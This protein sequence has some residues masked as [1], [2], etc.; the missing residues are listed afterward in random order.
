MENVKANLKNVDHHNMELIAQREQ[1]SSL[2]LSIL[3]REY[4][5]D[6]IDKAGV[7]NSEFYQDLHENNPAYQNN[8]WFAD[9]YI[10]II[11]NLGITSVFEL[12][13]GNGKATSRLAQVCEKVLACDWNPNPY[14]NLPN[15]EFYN[16]SF[17][18]PI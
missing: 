5:P 17:F 8:N 14:H 13:S 16:C 11:Q 7:F 9:K 12:G 6:E 18:C 4:V 1:L 3:N 2:F 15:V 10:D